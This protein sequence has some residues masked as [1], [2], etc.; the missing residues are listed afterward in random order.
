MRQPA[1]FGS[2]VDDRGRAFKIRPQHVFGW[3]QGQKLVRRVVHFSG[4]FSAFL[5][6]YGIDNY[7]LI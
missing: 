3:Q 5:Y 2:L 7:A 4:F 6:S 1:K